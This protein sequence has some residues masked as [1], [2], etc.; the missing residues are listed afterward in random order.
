MSRPT[1]NAERRRSRH[2]IFRLTQQE[3]DR[4]CYKAQKAGC[5]PNE[6]ARKFTRKGEKSLVIKTYHR[7][8]P[9]FLKRIDRIG[10]NLNQ[11]VKNG[12]IF[13]RVNPR[14]QGTLERINSLID[15]AVEERGDG[16]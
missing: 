5:S 13:G 11:I 12:H 9:A 6:L 4:L 2:V 1:K 15:R 3:Y 8:D 10:H 16:A 14:I 7:L